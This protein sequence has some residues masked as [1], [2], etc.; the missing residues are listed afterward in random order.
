MQA[1]DDAPCL[2][3]T[4]VPDEQT[5][6][7]IAQVLVGDRLAACVTRLAP[8]RSTYRWQGAIERADEIPLLI[9]TRSGRYAQIEQRLR[10]LHPYDVPE[11]I[12]LAIDA[13]LPAYLQWLV[14]ETS[15][16]AGPADQAC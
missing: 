1:D 5:A 7:R 3:V 2:L 9:K 8:V 15:E 14:D 16:E 4:Q 10:T 11:L 12:V 6:D 13:G